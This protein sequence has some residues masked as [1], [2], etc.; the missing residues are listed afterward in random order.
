MT[1]AMNFVYC[2]AI[3]IRIRSRGDDTPDRGAV[4]SLRFSVDEILALVY[5][6]C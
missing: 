1:T 6:E 2:K 5:S 3:H 4:L